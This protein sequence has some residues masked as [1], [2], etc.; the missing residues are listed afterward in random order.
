MSFLKSIELRRTDSAVELYLIYN[1]DSNCA[2]ANRS[3]PYLSNQASPT[4]CKATAVFTCWLVSSKSERSKG[5][6]QI[7]DSQ[8]R[9]T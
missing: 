7:S 8:S 9:T 3:N 5:I 2:A 4:S 6:I 1:R